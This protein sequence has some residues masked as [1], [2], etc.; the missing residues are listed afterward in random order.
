[1][2]EPTFLESYRQ[3]MEAKAAY[4]ALLPGW[5]RGWMA[6]MG[7][8]LPSAFLLAP[9]RAEARWIVA[10]L[11]GSQATTIAIGMAFGWS[12]LWGLAH[13]LFWTPVVVLLWRRWPS[14]EWTPLLRGRRWR[15]TGALRVWLALVLG[16]MTV[17]LVF[18]HADVLRFVL[19]DR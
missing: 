4:V 13:V 11:L 10:A 2:S 3:A 12:R 19:G 15:L 8:V 18:D 5:V 14:L 7:V 6:W 9:F 1:M 16:T 17:S